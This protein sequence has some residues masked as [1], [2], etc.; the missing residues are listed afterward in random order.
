[1]LL[2]VGAAEAQVATLKEA[3]IA[4]VSEQELTLGYALLRTGDRA[5]Y[6]TLTEKQLASG[7]CTVLPANAR[8]IVEEQFTWRGIVRFRQLQDPTRSLFIESEYVRYDPSR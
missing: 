6:R 2:F 8:L 7:R 5:A 1:M 3:A 4:C